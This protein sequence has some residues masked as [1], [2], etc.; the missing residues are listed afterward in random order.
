MRLTFKNQDLD[1]RLTLKRQCSQT[2]NGVSAD[3]IA[4]GRHY[5]H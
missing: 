5:C 2:R 4:V 1:E 3:V